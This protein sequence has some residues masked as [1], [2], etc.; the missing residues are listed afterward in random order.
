MPPKIVANDDGQYFKY[1]IYRLTF[2]VELGK[3]SPTALE[4]KH[5]DNLNPSLSCPNSSSLYSAFMNSPNR[6]YSKTTFVASLPFHASQKASQLVGVRYLAP[7]PLGIDS[8]NSTSITWCG[9]RHKKRW[10]QLHLTL[11]CTHWLTA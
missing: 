1:H 6:N 8:L 10:Q 4:G 2:G 9:A 3:N 11:S 5:Q 7:S